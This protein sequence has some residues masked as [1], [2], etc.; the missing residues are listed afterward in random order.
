MLRLLQLLFGEHVHKL[1]HHDP[2][3]TAIA[4]VRAVPVDER[5]NPIKR[6]VGEHLRAVNLPSDA[7][8]PQPLTVDTAY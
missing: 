3:A 6:Y 4:K 2:V 7:E 1:L 8:P 5:V